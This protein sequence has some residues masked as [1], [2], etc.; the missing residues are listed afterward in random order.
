VKKFIIV[1]Y[2]HVNPVILSNIIFSLLTGNISLL[3]EQKFFHLFKWAGS[4][5]IKIYAA[6]Q[7][8]C[9]PLHLMI[10]RPLFSGNQ[11]DDFLSGRIENG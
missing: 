7:P 11:G 2:N 1:K 3:Q 10:S 5:L 8:I 4:Q 6:R 9:M